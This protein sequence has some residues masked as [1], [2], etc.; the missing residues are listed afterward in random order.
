[1]LIFIDTEFTDFIDCELISIG[2][3][4]EDGQ[5][6]FY[7]EVQDFDC[8][9]CNPYVQSGIWPL[10]GKIP[11][12]IMKRAELPPGLHT[13]FTGLPRS[14]TIAC[15]SYTDWEL[16]VDVFDGDLTAQITGRYDL[17][18]LIN[19]A[20]FNQAVCQY[21]AQPG[22]PWHHA[23]HDAQAQRAGWLA[24]MEVNKGRL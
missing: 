3:V 11:D 23:L 10:L 16:L 2:M 15:D 18:A 12:A 14:V 9:K 8:A 5:H 7:A 20:V 4:S 19:T 6:M 13:W 21:H 1:M 24:W 17:R 22:Q